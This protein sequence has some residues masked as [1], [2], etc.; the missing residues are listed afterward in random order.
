MISTE[1]VDTVRGRPAARVPVELDYFITGH[2]WKQVGNGV[3]NDEGLVE[4]FGE[5]AAAGIYRLSFDVA[6][7]AEDAFFPSITV[8]FEARDAEAAYHL[9]LLLN[10]HGYSTYRA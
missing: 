5:P 3:S 4:T 8:L 10:G 7:Y 1:I 2:G 6:S 9:P